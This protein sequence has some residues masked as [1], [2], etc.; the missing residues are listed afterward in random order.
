MR[1]LS[2]TDELA[3]FIAGLK[4]Y[5]QDHADFRKRTFGGRP[6]GWISD[7]TFEEGRT[8]GLESAIE[9]IDEF[10]AAW[11]RDRG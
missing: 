5:I 7:A 6:G 1:R 2:I 8:E 10:V 11:V 9:D 3:A 4:A